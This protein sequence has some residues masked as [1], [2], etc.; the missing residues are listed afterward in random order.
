MNST[1]L[2]MFLIVV[3]LLFSFYNTEQFKSIINRNN[4]VNTENFKPK[5]IRFTKKNNVNL[6]DYNQPV[7]AINKNKTVQ[8]PM[9]DTF[10]NW[11]D[12]IKE[13]YPL[14]ENPYLGLTIPENS[15]DKFKFKKYDDDNKTIAQLFEDNSGYLE[16][17]ITD[18]QLELIGGKSFDNNNYDIVS[19]TIL[20]QEYDSQFRDRETIS[21]FKAYGGNLFGSSL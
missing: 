11:E 3:V 9:I 20:F 14:E 19:D 15:N 6:F 18:K 7:I 17:D 16:N 5:K 8:E 10:D 2:L 1:S 21:K 4:N 12:E 13:L